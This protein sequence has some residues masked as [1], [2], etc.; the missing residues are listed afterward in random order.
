LE[1]ANDD[2]IEKE[3]MMKVLSTE[4]LLQGGGSGWETTVE[5]NLVDK[6]IQALAPRMSGILLQ[7][8]VALGWKVIQ[9]LAPRMTGV[10]S[11]AEVALETEASGLEVE[12]A[13]DMEHHIVSRLAAVGGVIYERCHKETWVYT[14]VPPAPADSS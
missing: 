10:P 3:V 12:I 11:Q 9:T 4:L 2:L 13:F 1:S 6:V 5:D 7:A 14:M 8:K